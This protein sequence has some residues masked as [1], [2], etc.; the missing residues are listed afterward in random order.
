MIGFPVLEMVI[1]WS[2]RRETWAPL[3]VLRSPVALFKQVDKGEVR[4]LGMTE[5]RAV[6]CLTLPRRTRVTDPD[7][8]KC[9]ICR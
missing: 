4:L 6:N 3:R 7:C 8:W 2:P 1:S 9:Q 5:S